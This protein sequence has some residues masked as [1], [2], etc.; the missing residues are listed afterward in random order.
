MK[1]IKL[2]MQAF[3]PYA[4]YT[5]IDFSLMGAQGLFL[6]TGDTGAG[7]TMIFDALTFALYGDTSGNDRKVNSLRSKT[8]DVNDE[9]YV[10]LTF[11]HKGNEY[12][13]RR[14]PTHA[15]AKRVGGNETTTSHNA[16][17]EFSD[18][19]VLSGVTDVNEKVEEILGIN[20]NQF[21]QIALIG[22]GEFRE[23]LN[24]KSGARSDIF[25]KIFNTLYYNK[26]ENILKEKNS[27]LYRS[28]N[29]QKELIQNTIVGIDELKEEEKIYTVHN[30]E[31]VLQ[32]IESLI[33][34]DSEKEKELDSIKV[35]ITNASNEA[36]KQLETMRNLKELFDNLENV[37]V[38]LGTLKLSKD[39]Y[40][41]IEKDLKL[42]DKVISDVYPHYTKR[43]SLK[44]NINTLEASI[45][46]IENDVKKI[47][48]KQNEAKKEKEI[49]LSRADEI[50]KDKLEISTISGSLSKYK[51][52]DIHIDSEAKISQELNRLVSSVKENEKS[53][54]QALE[55]E[56][57]IKKNKEEKVTLGTSFVNVKAEILKYTE[58]LALIKEIKDLNLSTSKYKEALDKTLTL[59]KS[60]RNLFTLAEDKFYRSQGAILAS[61]LEDHK[62]CPVCGSL[63]HPSPAQHDED[64]MDKEDID[65]LKAELNELEALRD[66]QNSDYV[67]SDTNLK[68]NEKKFATYNLDAA[69][70]EEKYAELTAQ[71]KSLESR[72]NKLIDLDKK[73]EKVK[74]LINT[75]IESID[76]DK[77][78]ISERKVDLSSITTSIGILNKELKFDNL[79]AAEIELKAL[80]SNVEKYQEALELN[81]KTIEKLS[82]Q[83]ANLKGQLKTNKASLD[84]DIQ[85]LKE[86]SQTFLEALKQ[87]SIADEDAF[88]E[89][90]KLQDDKE[91]LQTSLSKYKEDLTEETARFKLLQDK[92]QGQIH[93][94]INKQEAVLSELKTSLGTVDQDLSKLQIVIERNTRNIKELKKQYKKYTELEDEYKEVNVLYQT[95]TGNLSQKDKITFEYYVQAA[96]FTKVLHEANKRFD[97]MSGGKYS[98]VLAE[99]TSDKRLSTG[100]DLDVIDHHT[101][102]R[103]EVSTLSGGESFK[104]ALSLALGMSDVIQMFAGGIEINML[105]VDEG[106]G[107]LDA[108]SLDQA[109]L[110]LND[111]TSYDRVIGIIS[112]VSELKE[113]I[114]KKILVKKDKEGSYVELI[115]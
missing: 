91:R 97:I 1:P 94:D 75:L 22:Q 41:K 61:T 16:S 7:K 29:V 92:T 11:L 111:L 37:K 84:K 103:R 54:V 71:K 78:K 115:V 31:E 49:L 63:D 48:E 5:E 39:K 30:V 53:H 57:E 87:A 88:V 8:A 100:L 66:K 70:T 21:K 74:L 76:K 35:K 79:Q 102:S 4:K 96:Y 60:K 112:H 110:V 25:R 72:L 24:A 104:A 62:P 65:A 109:I 69:T 3:G 67:S 86:A 6:L 20:H 55:Q 47:D 2:E 64:V 19:T 34:D 10:K 32:Y 26:F 98:L 18:R 93:P 101:N 28:L 106:F 12:I 83:S 107:S 44:T 33:L 23:L 17:I 77:Q 40:D 42:L 38:T 9:T 108:E 82:N 52:L 59:L 113:R 73:E 95:A 81:T 36:I 99:G 56:E 43:E 46:D 45:Q 90:I 50:E 85:L 80:K 58:V 68:L 105:F 15:Y 51:E 114:D 89:I 14:N 13:V 27:Q